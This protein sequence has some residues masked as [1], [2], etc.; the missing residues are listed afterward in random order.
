MTVEELKKELDKYPEDAIVIV[1]IDDIG[2]GSPTYIY[3]VKE[4]NELH[5]KFY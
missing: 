1:P 4:T 3:Y 2:D 5:L